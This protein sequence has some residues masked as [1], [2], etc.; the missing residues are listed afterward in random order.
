MKCKDCHYFK[1]KKCKVLDFIGFD[2]VIN[3]KG[4]KEK[5]PNA[6]YFEITKSEPFYY[7]EES[8]KDNIWRTETFCDL[9]ENEDCKYFINKN[10]YCKD[11][12]YYKRYS[13]NEKRCSLLDDIG[14]DSEK[15]H[16]GIVVKVKNEKY[17]EVIRKTLSET[18]VENCVLNENKDCEYF[19]SKK[20][21]ESN[22]GN[23]EKNG[24][25][26]VDPKNPEII[27][28]KIFEEFGE[29]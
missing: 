17:H 21:K 12:E 7:S 14:W 1:S 29:F 6:N 11:S 24:K 23:N 9:K 8:K 19:K 16:K 25:V 26:F 15:D 27:W 22:S 20:L 2:T 3:H 5:V 18:S 10:I 4:D 13:G 28:Q